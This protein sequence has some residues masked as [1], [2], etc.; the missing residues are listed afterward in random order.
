MYW[1]YAFSDSKFPLTLQTKFLVPTLTFYYQFWTSSV[2]VRSTYLPY[3][4]EVLL[5]SDLPTY[6][7]LDKLC[8]SQI[9]L[10]TL[11]WRSAVKVRSTYLLYFGEVLLKSGLPTYPIL[12][13]LCSS[14]I[15][16]PTLPTC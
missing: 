10:P 16:L 6:P 14:Q 9:Y 7:I 8:S 11:F 5:K 3:F 4:G 13:K 2:K 1:M 15:Y 12:D